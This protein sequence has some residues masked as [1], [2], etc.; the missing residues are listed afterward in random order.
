WT[1]TPRRP[2]PPS[3]ICAAGLVGA[4]WRHT[5]AAGVSPSGALTR[6]LRDGMA[7]DLV[8]PEAPG[9]DAYGALA[10]E[11][12]TI[13]PGSAGLAVLA[14]FSGERTPINDPDA[15]GL[16]AGLSLAHTRAHLFRAASEGIAYGVRHDLE[17]MREAGARTGRVVAVSG[18]TNNP[19][20]VR[21]VSDV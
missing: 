14:Y 10:R 19:L 1:V 21:I 15:R 6:W 11:A 20:W 3:S 7:P 4:V 8:T 2:T 5:L 12:A 16:I 18:G 13:R 17:V 9:A